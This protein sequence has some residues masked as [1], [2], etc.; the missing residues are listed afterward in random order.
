MD[1]NFKNF[2]QAAL[3]FVCVVLSFC[4]WFGINYFTFLLPW[5]W[6]V[7]RGKQHTLSADTTNVIKNLNQ[8]VKVTALF[9]GIPPKYLEDL[10]RE[11]AKVSHGRIKTEIVDPIQQIGYAAQF[12]N[13][14]NV[15]ER[16]VF[17]TSGQQRKEVFFTDSPLTQEQLTN[18]I[19]RVNQDKRLVYFLT[20]HGELNIENKDDQGLSILVR[21]LDSNNFESRSLMLAITGGQIPKDCSVLIIA[22]P[23]KNLTKTEN[24]IIEN[25]LEKGGRA[26]FLVENV[27]VTTPD[28]PLPPDELDKNPSLNEILNNWG[29]NI[30]SDIVVDLSSHAGEDV[31]SPATK[32]Y[33]NHP[34]ITA[35]LDYTFYVRPRTIAVLKEY[36]STIKMAPVVLT[37]SK[38]ASWG[39]SDRML[40]VRF[41]AAEDTPGPVPIAYLVFE[42]K[43]KTDLADTRLIVF[44]DADFLSNA[45]IN[46]YSNAQMGLNVLNWLAETDY[47][48]FVDQEKIKV[49]R[50]DLTSQQKRIIASILFLMPVLIA[51]AGMIVWIKSR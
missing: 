1:P 30:K 48:V 45:Y 17:V 20:G 49:D 6:D 5:Q 43:E 16:K 46:Q 33:G 42:P 23:K 25:Y 18:A 34:A 22:G 26:L 27:I 41:D 31:G 9:A 37:A 11:Y 21:L 51:L 10:F 40:H 28:K 39:E 44:T 36:R 8:D 4:L 35:G 13:V 15:K 14:I 38:K 50:L 24:E 32:N 2:K 3:I 12:G 29:L 47:K 19:L 7:T